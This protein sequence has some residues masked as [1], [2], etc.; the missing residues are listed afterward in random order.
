MVL[1][2]T[3]NLTLNNMTHVQELR[4]HI[5][6]LLAAGLT[7]RE[8]ASRAHLGVG[9]IWDIRSERAKRVTVETSAALLKVEVPC[10]RT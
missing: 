9:T 7:Y 6:A 5:L 2:C 10:A 4:A 1:P 8:I 3:V